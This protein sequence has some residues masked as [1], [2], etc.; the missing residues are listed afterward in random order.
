MKTEAKYILIASYDELRKLMNEIIKE[1]P[2][3]EPNQAE[4]KRLNRAQAAKYIGV[5][6]HTI[7][8]WIRSGKLQERGFARKKFFYQDEIIEMLNTQDH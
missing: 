4:R 8:S 6:Y 2:K 1:M 3:Q 5:S 7:G